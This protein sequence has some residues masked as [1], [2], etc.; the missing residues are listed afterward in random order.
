MNKRENIK[1]KP[2][3]WEKL[4]RGFGFVLVHDGSNS[5][6]LVK[7]FPG[8]ENYA[9]E[10]FIRK[11]R[12]HRNKEL[13]EFLGDGEWEDCWVVFKYGKYDGHYISMDIMSKDINGKKERMRMKNAEVV[14]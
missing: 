13:A 3:A 11:Y 2:C 7:L 12:L 4:V 6:K 8:Q 9:S 10:Y 14:G 1:F 5:S